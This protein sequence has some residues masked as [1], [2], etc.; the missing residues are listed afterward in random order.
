M[1][2]DLDE[3]EGG[4]GPGGQ[5]RFADNLVRLLGLHALSANFTANLLGVSGATLSAWSNGKATPSLAKAIALAELFQLPTERLLGADFADLLSHELADEDR[6]Q[7]VE[8][9]I[10]RARAGLHPV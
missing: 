6:Y 5:L 7:R 10:R 1:S 3:L 2:S 8:D 9:R 4:G